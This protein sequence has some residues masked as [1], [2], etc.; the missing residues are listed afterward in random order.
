MTTR[1]VGNIHILQRASKH[2]VMEA[3]SGSCACMLSVLGTENQI[4]EKLMQ[5]TACA[6]SAVVLVVV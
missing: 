4:Q 3:S 5:P 6:F 1:W 2:E